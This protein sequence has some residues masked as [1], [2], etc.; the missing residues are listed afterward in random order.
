M[1][2][3]GNVERLTWSSVEGDFRKNIANDCSSSFETFAKPSLTSNVVH[4]PSLRISGVLK[5]GC[6]LVPPFFFIYLAAML[7]EVH[8]IL[9][10][11]TF[12]IPWTVDSTTSRSCD[13]QLE[14]RNLQH[15]QLT[16]DSTTSTRSVADLLCCSTFVSEAYD[17]FVMEVNADKT[18]IFTHLLGQEI[19]EITINIG[20]L[21]LK[22]V[23]NFQ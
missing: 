1:G 10:V 7:N 18:Q 16:N 6:I 11:L 5:Q 13:T 9:L 17:R 20:D 2:F 19:L 3:V 8:A 4:T 15:K 23:N 14:H 12:A 21:P 22:V